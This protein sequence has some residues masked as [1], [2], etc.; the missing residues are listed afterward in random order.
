[1][2]TAKKNVTASKIVPEKAGKWHLFT[3]ILMV[4][5]GIFMCFNPVETLIAV[6]LYL[7]IIFVVIGAAYFMASFSVKSGWYLAIGLLD[8][9]VGVIMISNLGLSVATLPM[10]F[11]LWCLAAGA[12]QMMVAYQYRKAG[13]PSKWLCVSGVL[14]VIFGILLL[15]YPIVGSLTLAL[16]FGLYVILYGLADIAQAVS[17]KA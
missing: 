6:A 7:G 17:W 5:L 3:G 8:I 11:A 12:V 9:I 16:I 4:L 15:A 10:I 14:G 1:M 13:Y 2:V